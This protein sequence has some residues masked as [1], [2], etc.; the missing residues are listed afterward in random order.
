MDDERV[1]DWTYLIGALPADGVDL[2]N[3]ADPA[4][5]LAVANALGLASVESLQAEWTVRPWHRSGVRVIGI[6]NADVVQTCGITLEPVAAR[7]SE[8]V[9]RRYTTDERLVAVRADDRGGFDID[10][11]EPDPPDLFDGETLDLGAIAMEHLALG[12]DPYPRAKD[13]AFEGFETAQQATLEPETPAG[14][15]TSP[16]AALATLSDGKPAKR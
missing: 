14:G 11:E 12:I 9:D 3:A 7:I 13:A 16:F 10:P 15:Q 8:T 4:D 2:H 6:V 1:L 5:R